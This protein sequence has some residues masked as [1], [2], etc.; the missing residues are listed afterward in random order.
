MPTVEVLFVAEGDAA[1]KVMSTREVAPPADYRE[2]DFFDLTL[3][4][5]QAK[6]TDALGKITWLRPPPADERLAVK[7]VVFQYFASN[8]SRDTEVD[9]IV[10]LADGKRRVLYT[11]R[12]Q[13]D[14]T[15][16]KTDV[17]VERV[18]EEGK[19]TPALDP[20]KQ[21][22]DVKR[23]QGYLPSYDKDKDVSQL[24]QWLATRYKSIS[25]TGTTRQ[26]VEDSANKTL[27]ADAGKESWF[28]QNYNMDVLAPDKGADRLQKVHG[29]SKERAAGTKSFQATELRVV[30]VALETMPDKMLGVLSG[31]Q[32]VRQRVKL[33]PDPKAPAD[34]P[35]IV[36]KPQTG[37]EAIDDLHGQRT[38]V[39]YDSVTALDTLLFSGGAVPGGARVYATGVR[40]VV[41]EFGHF[42]SH[43]KPATAVVQ[44]AFEAQFVGDR[45]KIKTA[46]V[47]RYAG[48]GGPGEFFA[49]AFAIYH[50]DPAWMR[51]NLLDMWNWFDTLSRTGAPPP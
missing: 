3:E 39:V 28:A 15:G 27:N 32:L 50:T 14:A 48:T 49:E 22:L 24:K 43:T 20:A 13:R 42:V 36:E 41:H 25:P 51:A 31:T 40:N 38:M 16:K 18:G 6:R 5:E 7:F 26:D 23:V 8:K 37:A 35:A 11:L 10:P 45:A 34:K 9:V 44:F 2:H 33:V 47:T 21:K 12:F 1:R 19:D 17:E 29:L 46:P 30:E 4:A